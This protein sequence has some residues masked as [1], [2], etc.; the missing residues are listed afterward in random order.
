M[1]HP[2]NF[3]QESS[4]LPLR[5]HFYS[6]KYICGL[7]SVDHQTKTHVNISRDWEPIHQNRYF[8]TLASLHSCLEQQLLPEMFPG[9]Q[10]SLIFPFKLS[11]AKIDRVFHYA[12]CSGIPVHHDLISFVPFADVSIPTYSMFGA[13]ANRLTILHD[14]MESEAVRCEAGSPV[15]RCLQ[16][17]RLKLPLLSSSASLSQTKIG[18][19]A[20]A[21]TCILVT[22]IP[23]CQSH[24][25]TQKH[26]ANGFH[27]RDT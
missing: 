24:P 27:G 19:S 1:I 2:G 18:D 11:F 10:M 17:T 3:L 12:K 13:T 25:F 4:F 22:S 26:I 9:S 5:I 20:H 16:E 14:S 6:N 23:R 21:I 15:Q 8:V 7:Q